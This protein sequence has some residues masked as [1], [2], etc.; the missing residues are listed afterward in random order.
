MRLHRV[1]ICE[2]AYADN[3]DS[4]T[5]RQNDLNL[6]WRCCN[7]SQAFHFERQYLRISN[8][9]LTGRC[10]HLVDVQRNNHVIHASTN[11]GPEHGNTG[12]LMSPC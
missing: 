8:G 5:Q 10:V 7:I 3:E 2:H 9:V 6:E 11:A 12:H 1:Y 4:L